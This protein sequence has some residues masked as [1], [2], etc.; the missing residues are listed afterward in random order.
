M[1]KKIFEIKHNWNVFNVYVLK[2]T[3]VMLCHTTPHFS[4]ALYSELPMS[5]LR[6]NY[7]VQSASWYIMLIRW[8]DHLEKEKYSLTWIC[9]RV[10]NLWFVKS[11]QIFLIAQLPFR[12]V[13]PH[14]YE[15][16]PDVLLVCW[17]L[18]HWGVLGVVRVDI[19]RLSGGQLIIIYRA[20]R[21]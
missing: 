18:W 3:R 2:D 6:N 15:P 12:K 4:E 8:M 17:V 7:A 5:H 10:T 1:V 16:S 21:C 19:V 20:P 11:L 9:G 13:A 14:G